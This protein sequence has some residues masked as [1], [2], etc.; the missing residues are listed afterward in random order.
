MVGNDSCNKLVDLVSRAYCSFMKVW[1][2]TNEAKL[3]DFFG[4]RDFYFFVKNVCKAF[5]D[6]GLTNAE[7]DRTKVASMLRTSV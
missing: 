3:K 2:D 1:E 5:R 6:E 7:R 4:L